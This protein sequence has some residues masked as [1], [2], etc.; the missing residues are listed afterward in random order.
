MQA[1]QF[2]P[3]QRLFHAFNYT[4]VGYALPA[5]SD[6]CLAI[7]GKPVACI[8]GDGSLMLN[9]QKLATIKR[10]RLPIRLFVINNSGYSMVQQ[11]R[12]QWLGAQYHATSCEGGLDFLDFSLVAQSFEIPAVRI[13][14][15]SD[16]E[17]VIAKVMESDGAIL[18]DV[19]IPPEH[20]V[21]PLCRYGRPIEDAEPLLSRKEFLENMIVEPMSV[22]LE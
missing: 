12:E 16:V 18:C 13:E 15:N 22:S 6:G 14:K 5:A 4:P 8:E 1:F 21:V 19:I 3:G 17:R 9:L 2:K 7:G 20:R 10:H 11:S